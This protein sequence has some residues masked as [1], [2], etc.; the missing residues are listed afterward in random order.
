[1]DSDQQP[2]CRRNCDGQCRGILVY[3]IGCFFQRFMGELVCFKRYAAATFLS[4]DQPTPS[5]DMTRSKG[6]FVP[7]ITKIYIFSDQI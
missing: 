1:M 6:E 2:K 7:W 3:G 4:F 5:K